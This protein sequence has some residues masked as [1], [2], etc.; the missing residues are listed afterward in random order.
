MGEHELFDYLDSTHQMSPPI[1]STSPK[2]VMKA[3][4]ALN[5]KKAPGYN[6][7]SGKVLKELQGKQSS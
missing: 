4:S 2:K 7:I 5:I 3:I 6:L 1:M